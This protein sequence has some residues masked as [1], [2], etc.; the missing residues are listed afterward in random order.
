MDSYDQLA[1][2]EMGVRLFIDP[3]SVPRRRLSSSGT[4]LL[5]GN[6]FFTSAGLSYCPFARDLHELEMRPCLACLRTRTTWHASE[7]GTGSIATVL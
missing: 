3:A 2:L 6:F 4:Q 1:Q 7:H 5:P